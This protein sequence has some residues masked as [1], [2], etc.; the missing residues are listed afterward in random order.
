M[1]L[2]RLMGRAAN[3]RESLGGSS[4]LPTSNDLENTLAYNRLGK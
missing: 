2:N 4:L 1:R 3:V